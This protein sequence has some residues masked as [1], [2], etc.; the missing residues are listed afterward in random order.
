MKRVWVATGTLGIGGAERVTVA[1][2]NA[3]ADSGSRVT[4]YVHEARGG[5]HDGKSLDPRVRVLGPMTPAALLGRLEAERP[6]AF[7]NNI[8]QDL[9]PYLG[10]VRFHVR[11][12][13][14]IIHS[15]EEWSRTFLT[16]SLC[17]LYDRVVLVA[18]HLENVAKKWGVPADKVAVV[19]NPLDTDA[20]CPGSRAEARKALDLPADAFLIGYVGRACWGKRV[21]TLPGVLFHLRKK[22]PGAML[23]T[24][25]MVE[26]GQAER[27]AYWTRAR[28]AFLE[29]A[30]AL[31]VRNAI[32]E[33]TPRSDTAPV[34]RAIDALTLISTAEG[35]PLVLDEALACGTPFV[36][37]DVGHARTLAGPSTGSFV[38]LEGGTVPLEVGVAARLAMIASQTKAQRDAQSK[39]ARDRMVSTRGPVWWR[40][41]QLPRLL[42]AVQ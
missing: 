8:V 17:R 1:W 2:A 3:L 32:V 38:V 29:A 42:E 40:K 16:P 39:H 24:A 9:V 15:L 13:V 7:I 21:A 20:F 18:P 28:D 12:L 4:V 26:F 23:V 19:Q 36:A 41:T 10:V 5:I 6:D 34:Y 25:G 33:L 27:T 37:T 11:R 22:V 14:A 30:D 35:A 31:G